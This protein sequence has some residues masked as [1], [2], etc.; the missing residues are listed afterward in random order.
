MNMH[1]LE[2]ILLVTSVAVEKDEISKA[3]LVRVL[4]SLA[5]LSHDYAPEG[6]ESADIV[7]MNDEWHRRFGHLMYG[8]LD[9]KQD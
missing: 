9:D 7:K 8:D 4:G 6:D 2:H 1:C 3:E 5:S